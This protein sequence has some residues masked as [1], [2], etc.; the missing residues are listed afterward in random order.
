M[1]TKKILLASV[2]VGLVLPAYVEAAQKTYQPTW[3]SLDTRPTP[4]WFTDAKFGV[5]I[6][7]GLYSVPAW[8]PPGKYSEWYQYWLQQKSFQGQVHDFHVKTCGEDFEFKD[9]APRFK[10]E[11]WD[12]DA[13]ADLLEQAGAKYMVFTTKHHSGYTLWPSK[14][15]EE[16]YGVH[17]NPVKIGPKRDITGELCAAVR[18]KGIKA[19]L[20]YSLYEWYHPLYKTDKPR[21]V[22]E[23]LFPQFKDLVT[24]YQPDIVW[25]DGEWELPWETWR[26]PELLAWLFNHAPNEEDLV[27][28]DRWGKGV[29]HKHG[30]FYTTEYGSGMDDDSHPWEEN[31]GM[32]HSYGYNRAENLAHY[33]T[34]QELILM[35]ADVVSRGG[36]LCLDIGPR[37]DGSIPVIMQERLRQIGDWLKINGEAIYGTR[38]WTRPCQWSEGKVPELNRGEY[39]S[40]FNILE[41]TVAPPAGQ[42]YKEILFTS[43][44]DSVYAITP[45]WPGKTLIVKHIRPSHTTEVTLLETGQTLP[46]QRSGDHLE[47][48]MPTF[49]PDQIKGR[50]AHTFRVSHVSPPQAA[51]PKTVEEIEQWWQTGRTLPTAVHEDYPLRQITVKNDT[52]INVLIDMAHRCDFFTLWHLGG[53]LNQRGIRTIGSHATLDSVLTPGK[54]CRVRIPVAPKVYPFAWW[55]APRFN[56]VLTEGATHYPDYLPEERKALDEF[57]REGGG[58]IV[59][60]S[61]VK[62]QDTEKAWSLNRLLEA[63]GARILAGQETYQGKKWPQLKVGKDWEVVIKGDNGCPIYAQRMIGKGRI[64]L[65][66]SSALY[67]F[68]RKT[69]ADV[70][71]KCGFLT[72][73]IQWAAAGTEPVGGTTQFPRAMGGG[74]GIYPESE[75]R[76]DGIVCFYS[77]NQIPELMHT[78]KQDFPAITQDIY[79]WLPSPKPEQPMYMILCS[80]SGGGWAVNAYLPKE[81]STISTSSNGI[82][83]IFGHEQAHTMAGPCTAANHP[84][85]GNR[86][87]EHAGW[88]Q[89]KINAKYNGDTGPNRNCERV[90]QKAYDGTQTSPETIFV[91][92]NLEA[93][94]TDHDRM[95]IWYVWQKLD[96]RYGPTWYPRWRWVQSQR[97]QHDPDRKLTWEESIEDMSIAVGEDL[98]PF[99]AKTGKQLQQQRFARVVFQGRNIDLPV[100]AIEPT[101][102]GDVCLEGIGDYTKAITIR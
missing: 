72:E 102:P 15:A 46:W 55:P 29:R 67:R 8:S 85:G 58:L 4:Q 49:D 88:F 2:M 97:W 34:A 65:V 63:Y 100:A 42:A 68:D 27:I 7:W 39:M 40:R 1:S 12:P 57:I 89:G 93:W 52:G 37:A 53:A 61:N 75:V 64:A 48:N 82:R 80:G 18:K 11:L 50:T 24:R 86:G 32:G 3:E 23:H 35:L 91:P 66:A 81:A 30:S 56:V 74:G 43:K 31:R 45:K 76:I 22:S 38:M 84:F 101:P 47:I 54:P 28:N 77:K 25:S 96:D 95:M 94:R 6:C 41:Q 99:F 98:F 20:Y 60:G 73:V 21:F 62:D 14:E 26:S 79:A 69:R 10:A 51:V 16:T 70:N 13:W 87:E 17:Y 36:N 5:F 33:R 78:L 83:S 90:F 59:A 71:E 92:R 9:F 19:G 44:Q